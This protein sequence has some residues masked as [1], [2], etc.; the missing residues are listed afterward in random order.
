MTSYLDKLYQEAVAKARTKFNISRPGSNKVVD[1][2]TQPE[3]EEQGREQSFLSKYL[4][5]KVQS[6]LNNYLKSPST[7]AYGTYSNP[8]NANMPIPRN[9]EF[10]NG[11]YAAADVG[12]YYNNIGIDTGGGSTGKSGMLSLNSTGSVLGILQAALAVRGQGADPETGEE[13]PWDEKTSQQKTTSS[14]VMSG[15]L[16]PFWLT[17]A[18]SK[19][20]SPLIDFLQRGEYEVMK[21]LYD[22]FIKGP[23][24]SQRNNSLFFPGGTKDR[25][26]KTVTG[27]KVE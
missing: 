1:Y 18:L 27:T 19:S 16:A 20:E 13:I 3:P 25:I 17:S 24:M 2:T 10:S 7:S 12:Q 23:S 21:P 9:I 15:N 22:F 14:P 6:Y 8:Y 26:G 5:N 11:P 4:S